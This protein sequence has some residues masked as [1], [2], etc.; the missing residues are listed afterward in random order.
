MKILHTVEF[1]YPS[2]GGTQEVIRHLSE[3]M[4]K[5]GHEVYVATTKLPERDF[6]EWNGVH[7]VE[8]DLKG[9][10]VNGIKGPD[11][12]KYKDFL[13]KERFDVTMNY[14]AQQWATDLFLDVM[15]DVKAKKVFVPCGFS[16]LY[17]PDYEKYFA[18]MPE[19]L[20]KYDQLVFL[21]NDYRDINF[22]REHGLGG[23]SIV[24]PNG[25]D[26]TEFGKLATE[27]E[28]QFIRARYGL[29]GL[30][31]TTIGNHT[32]EK[33]HHE[34]MRAFK[35][36]PATPATLV[37]VGTI[38]PHD[39]CYDLCQLGADSCNNGR[40]FLGKRIILMDGSN[41]EDVR[42][43]LKASDI[44]GFFSNIECSPLAL[45]EAVAAGVPFV[46]SA[47]GNDREIAAWTGGGVIVQSHNM[48]NGRVK[49]S[50]KDA[51]R[52]LTKLAYNKTKRK[53][54]GRAGHEAWR[55]SYTWDKLTR[56]YIDLYETL[57]KKG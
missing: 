14:A 7:I 38:K 18:K 16:A 54:M 44:F 30:V 46:A 3:R 27:E 25:A 1:Y 35:M 6:T 32:N 15:D 43:L 5:A 34:L 55:K 20:A 2:I 51:V 10:S 50:A 57:V 45:F 9:N 4:V 40:K 26:E 21:A 41:R 52:Q 37:I 48:P 24:I 31:I 33:G 19:K 13:I 23:K 56:D 8:F 47:A 53:A 11:V 22:A 36:L 12:Q 28:K 29:G 17:D 49:V 42:A 39:G